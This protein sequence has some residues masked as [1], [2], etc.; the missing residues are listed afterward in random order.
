MNLHNPGK[1]KPYEARVTRGGKSVNL[2]SF[3]K[4]EEAALCIARSPE[5]RKAAERVAS[6]APPRRSEEAGQGP[7][8]AMCRAR[9][10]KKC[11]CAAS[12]V[13]WAAE[14]CRRGPVSTKK[15]LKVNDRS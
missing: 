3:A 8:P 12:R 2:G 10:Q 11:V 5:G 9:V 6:A 1:L 4:A 14:G 7:V 13:S 15:R